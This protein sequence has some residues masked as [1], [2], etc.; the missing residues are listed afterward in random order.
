M[1]RLREDVAGANGREAR[2]PPTLLQ[3]GLSS[4]LRN[5]APS[6]SSLAGAGGAAS[7]GGERDRRGTLRR[8]C[9]TSDVDH[10]RCHWRSAVGPV[11]AV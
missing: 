2:P 11:E 10:S 1:P 3:R 8:N 4:A 5:K 7:C 9:R 6:R